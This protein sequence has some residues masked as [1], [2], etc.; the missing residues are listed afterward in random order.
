MNHSGAKNNIFVHVTHKMSVLK[1]TTSD[2]DYGWG[3]F[4]PDG[5]MRTRPSAETHSMMGAE[6][7]LVTVFLS[8]TWAKGFGL[9]GE[10]RDVAD[11]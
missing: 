7:S 6:R 11:D 8:R 5:E 3:V 2:V 1:N 10:H 9:K 4:R